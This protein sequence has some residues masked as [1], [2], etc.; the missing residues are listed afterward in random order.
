MNN[1][2]YISFS[3]LFKSANTVQVLNMCDSLSSSYNVVLFCFQGIGHKNIKNYYNLKN[4]FKIVFLT[5]NKLLNLFL[6]ISQLILLKTKPIIYTRVYYFAFLFSFLD[7]NVFYEKHSVSN[8]FLEKIVDNINILFKNLKTVV[9]SKTLETF[10]R[11]RLTYKENL[12]YA[13][14]CGQLNHS[15]FTK[16]CSSKFK[17]IVSYI[18]SLSDGK[19]LNILLELVRL[20]PNI[21][22]IIAGK[23]STNLSNRFYSYKNVDFRGEV[24]YAESLNILSVSSVGLN[25]TQNFG[26][27]TLSHPWQSPLKLFDYMSMGCTIISSSLDMYN[28]ILSTENSLLIY[29]PKNINCWVN[30]INLLESNV[31]LRNKLARNAFLLHLKYFNWNKRVEYIFNENCYP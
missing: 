22:F 21:S 14:D 20:L 2:F 16:L 4:N 10:F 12:I 13:P 25:P 26:S 3:T 29:D 8:N 1:L 23:S 15:N 28:G 17:F 9:I 27:T 19:G 30:S 11:S 6:I 24:S 18:G 31:N 7:Y 5:K